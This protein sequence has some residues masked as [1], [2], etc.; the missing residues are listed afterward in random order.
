MLIDNEK[1]PKQMRNVAQ[2]PAY[3]DVMKQLTETYYKLREQYRVPAD[4]PGSGH[5]IPDFK[6]SWGTGENDRIK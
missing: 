1:D 3:A 2:D 5:R 4:C 6:P